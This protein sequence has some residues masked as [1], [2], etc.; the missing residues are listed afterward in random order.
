MKRIFVACAAVAA[1]GLLASSAR[2][3][4]SAEVALASVAPF[5]KALNAEFAK[6]SADLNQAI[7][8]AAVGLLPGQRYLQYP[9]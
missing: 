2:A 3:E 7:D 1:M 9:R 8:G 6:D 4:F 5:Y